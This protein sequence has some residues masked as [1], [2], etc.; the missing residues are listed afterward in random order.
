MDD[1]IIHSNHHRQ[2]HRRHHNHNHNHNLREFFNYRH[3]NSRR[4]W[5]GGSGQ[6]LLT[7]FPLHPADPGDPL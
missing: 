3:P 4:M 6:R 2:Q 1:D 5:K 7:P